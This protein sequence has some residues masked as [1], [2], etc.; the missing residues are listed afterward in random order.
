MLHKIK[1]LSELSNILKKLKGN[2]K[3]IVHC[4]G[5]FDL[6][7]PGHLKHFELARSLG[8]V[9]IVTVTA[10]KYVNKGPNKPVYNEKLRAESIAAL[11]II[12]YV[13][14]NENA[15]SIE[16]IYA[17]EPNIYV[18]GK[19]YQNL[20]DSLGHIS[21]EKEAV[22]SVGGKLTFVG[23]T[24]FSST[25]L[26]NE[27]FSI[28][29]PETKAYLS[30]FKEVYS[31]EEIEKIIEIFKTKNVLV[32]GDIVIDEYVFCEP[33]GIAEKAACLNAK[34]L[35]KEQHLGGAAGIASHLANFCQSV[36]FIASTKKRSEYS[37]FF[38]DAMHSKVKCLLS[39][40]D[41]EHICMKQRFFPTDKQ[42]NQL[43]ELTYANNFLEIGRCTTT[44]IHHISEVIKE[45]DLVIVGDYGYGMISTEMIEYLCETDAYLA[46]L[47]QT[48]N[49]NMGGNLITK[50]SRSNYICLDERELKLA[51][52]VPTDSTQNLIQELSNRQNCE[53]ISL[54]SGPNGSLNWSKNEGFK[55]SVAF[56]TEVV[57]STGAS[58]A[59]FA[60][61]AL[62]AYDQ[63]SPS[64]IGFIGNCAGAIM[65]RTLGHRE[66]ITPKSLY[67]VA[68]GL[69]K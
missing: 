3:K 32:I 1:S 27:Y 48:N 58:S 55:T 35:G 9:L 59:Y 67:Q 17:L 57:D 5:V 51:S 2:K 31:L 52:D 26:L 24:I 45:V 8:E 68:T 16:A 23:E 61:T 50:Y 22:E 60:L 20:K 49:Y 34:Y 66:Y 11:E 6:L 25:S 33:I 19:E 30:E 42:S 56:T 10:D 4:H 46:V 41:D 43:F 54:I 40:S 65:V 64:L 44:I 69:L 13:V 14:I 38:V 12:D 37:N 21:R 29:T 39:E 15:S 7:H 62:C 47:A 53:L 63:L 36:Y 18:K 28:L